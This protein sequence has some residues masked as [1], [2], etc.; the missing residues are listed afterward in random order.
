MSARKYAAKAKRLLGSAPSEWLEPR[1][2]LASTFVTIP[3]IRDIVFD[4]SHNMLY[5]T[6]SNSVARYNATTR[7][8]L[9]SFTVGG[10]LNGLDV[11]PDGNFIYAADAF[12]SGQGIVRKIN[13]S[14]G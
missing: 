2:L 5:A 14:S 6:A 3:S 7:A 9:S 13:A 11:T 1:R 4:D 10:A 12:V 8:L